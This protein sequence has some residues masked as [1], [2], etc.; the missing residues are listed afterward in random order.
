MIHI[1][2]FEMILDSINKNKLG[3]VFTD[4]NLISE[5]L[6]KLQWNDPTKTYYDP[7]C[8]HGYFL[9]FVYEILMGNGPKY[10]GY[11]NITGLKYIIEDDTEREKHIIE[12]MLFGNDIQENS[13]N[14]CKKL[15]RSDIYKTNFTCK[16]F[17]DS[18]SLIKYDN[19]IGNPPFEDFL[20]E[21]RKAKNHNLWRPI[22]LKAYSMLNKGGYMAFVCPQSWM[23]YSKTN[24]DMLELFNKN[25]IIKLNINEC[26]KYFKG[27]GSSF[28]Y[29]VIENVLEKGETEV[30]CEYK[31]IIYNSSI[32]FHNKNEFFPLLIN[33]LSISILNKTV[34]NKNLLKYDLKFDSYLH[35]YTKKEFLSKEQDNIFKYKVWHTPN[36]ILWSK[37]PHITQD[38]WKVLIPISTYYETL[39]IDKAGNTQGMGYVLCNTEQEA[40]KIKEILSLKLYRFLVNINRWSNWNSPDILRNLPKIEINNVNDA[41]LY[42]AF[43]LTKEESQFI[44]KTIKALK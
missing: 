21:K 38:T 24:K 28:S 34:L 37:K 9:Y 30:I 27:V 10:K 7:T 17:L 20:N 19:I 42:K 44:E 36:S 41:E 23:S 13:I 25:H 31:N 15:F 6:I 2:K 40:I 18:D 32:V 29:F 12:N 5:M 8:G 16:N 22:I 33:D 14:E 26:R 35:A 4:I 11:E 3:E 1:D 43:N 39:L